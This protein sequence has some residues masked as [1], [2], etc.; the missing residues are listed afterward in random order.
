MTN[1]E[2]TTAARDALAIEH[3]E[4]DGTLIDGTAKGDGS[5][6]ILKAHGWRWSRR[7][8]SW[9]LPHT[10][11]VAPKTAKINATAEALRAASFDVTVTIQSGVRDMAQVEADRADRQA[12][13][14]TALDAKADRKAAAA[15]AAHDRADELS[16]RYPMGQPILV[17][18]HSEARHRRDIERA[19]NADDAAWQADRDAKRAKAKADAARYTTDHRYQPDRIARRIAT[20]EADRRRA[21]RNLDGHTRTIAKHTTGGPIVH[22]TA[23]ATGDYADQLRDSI[24]RLDAQITYWRDVREAQEADGIKLYTRADIKPGDLVK[25]CGQWRKV[26]RVNAKSVSVETGYSWTDTA[27]YDAITDVADGTTGQTRKPGEAA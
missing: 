9:Y 26:K 4:A 17:G 21:Q 10:R 2:N 14:V 5:A 8:G 18:H 23:A 6:Q 16:N 27:K 12:D 15:A 3:T 11:D 13:R 25:I 19:H 7:L 24:E 1:A 22:T 20:L